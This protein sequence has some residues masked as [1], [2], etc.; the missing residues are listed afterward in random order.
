MGGMC[1][2]HAIRVSLDNI[3]S[4]RNNGDEGSYSGNQKEQRNV[5][6]NNICDTLCIPL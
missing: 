3:M 5:N 2:H 6:K 1:S 4:T